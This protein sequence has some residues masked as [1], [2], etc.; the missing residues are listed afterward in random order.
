MNRDY[1]NQAI[2]LQLSVLKN[3]NKNGELLY[4]KSLQG[5]T[6]GQMGLA[7]ACGVQI[8]DRII[9]GKNTLL[10]LLL[11]NILLVVNSVPMNSYADFKDIMSRLLRKSDDIELRIENIGF[12]PEPGS[13]DTS[14]VNWEKVQNFRFRSTEVPIEDIK[15]IEALNLKFTNPGIYIMMTSREERRKTTARIGDKIMEINGERT[16]NMSQT[17]FEVE[18]SKGIHKIYYT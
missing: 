11:A 14:D 6:E 5:S 13:N 7:E 4:V 10:S 15:N 18:M 2:D 3:K 17:A 12:T 8:G 9:E 1:V 16:E